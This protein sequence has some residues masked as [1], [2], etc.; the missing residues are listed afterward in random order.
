[1]IIDKSVKTGFRSFTEWN[2]MWCSNDNQSNDADRDI[3]SSF[4][5]CVWQFLFTFVSSQLQPLVCLVV[6]SRDIFDFGYS[7]IRIIHRFGKF[8]T[9]ISKLLGHK[10]GISK[11]YFILTFENKSL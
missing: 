7:L 10:L 1:M 5:W 6:Y 2:R 11:R 4:T 9:E 3:S 8:Q